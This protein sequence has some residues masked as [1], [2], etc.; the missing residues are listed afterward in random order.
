MGFPAETAS[1]RANDADCLVAASL[2]CPVCLHGDAVWSLGGDFWDTWADCSCP[3]CGHSR[4][5]F[6]A[7]DQALRLSLHVQRPLDPEP[8]PGELG[9]PL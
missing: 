5:V 9:I 7:G 3:H 8:H 2:A 1:F 4:R 6:L